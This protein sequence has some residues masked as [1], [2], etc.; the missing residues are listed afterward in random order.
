MRAS[1]MVQVET[2]ESAAAVPIELTRGS[3]SAAAA[4]AQRETLAGL[5][6]V[7]R[8]LDRHRDPITV[9]VTLGAHGG[10]ASGTAR[11]LIVVL[12]PRAPLHFLDLSRRAVHTTLDEA[13]KVLAGDSVLE[14]AVSKPKSH[15]QHRFAVR[16]ASETQ[17]GPGVLLLSGEQLSDAVRHAST[18]A[19]LG[20]V[21]P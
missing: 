12:S 17:M 21:S 15:R 1:S 9:R 18:S 6:D 7:Q 13:V 3:T 4:I 14:V 11:P 10:R 5:L 19:A 16:L 2:G 8:F 20:L